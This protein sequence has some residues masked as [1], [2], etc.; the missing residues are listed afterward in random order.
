MKENQAPNSVLEPIIKFDRRIRSVHVIDSSGKPVAD[1]DRPGLQSLEPET[2]TTTFFQR[3]AI[4]GMMGTAEDRFH[5]RTKTVI[6][7]R[8]KVI[9]ICYMLSGR[10]MLISADPAFPLGK[11]RTLGELIDELNLESLAA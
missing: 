7:I 8:E 9:L 1:A 3:T 10:I 5:G 2:V 11:V 4:A 6:A